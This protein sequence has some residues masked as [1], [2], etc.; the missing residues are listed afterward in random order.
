MKMLFGYLL[1]REMT[2]FLYDQAEGLRGLMSHR[3]NPG[4]RVIT[5]AGGM[6]GVGKTT[7]AVNMA[8]VLAE[9]GKRVLLIDENPCPDNIGARFGLK[10]RFDLL[11]AINQ[12]RRLDQVVLQGSENVFVLSASRGMAALSSL[13]ALA[14]NR[15]VTN[16]SQLTDSIDVILIDTAM[17]GETQ[18]LPLSLASEQVLIVI[19]GSAASLT[20]AYALIKMMSQEYAKQNFMVFVN[21]A[22]TMQSAYAVYENFSHVV[23]QYL[24]VSLE[25]AGYAQSDK[26]IH[27]ANRLC[28]P[29][30]HLFSSSQ[31]AN[32]FRQLADNVMFAPNVEQYR[33]KANDFMQRLIHSCHLSMANFTV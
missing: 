28:Q 22:D 6:K 24:S 19:S 23:Q 4:A 30:I 14:Q 1:E 2:K 8:A 18:I 5:L 31:T 15:L 32:Y 20:G 3:I 33:G 25:L 10:T 13:G 29:V 11:H 12:D 17:D 9:Q 21:K 26:R 27:Q 16:F 7:I